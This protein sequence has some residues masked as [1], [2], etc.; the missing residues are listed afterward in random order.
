MSFLGR[1][2]GLLTRNGRE[3]GLL[4]Q[5][6]EHAKAKRPEK[7]IDIY[8]GLLK[9]D[10]IGN[11]VRARALFNRALAYSSLKDY[12]RAG[13]DL[14]KVLAMPDVPENVQ[15]AARSQLARVRRR[16]EK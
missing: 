4:L 5:G 9:T 10:S 6:I 7:A 3:D 14:D 12:E 1:L 15:T 11:S 16:A 2:T 8:N 13:A